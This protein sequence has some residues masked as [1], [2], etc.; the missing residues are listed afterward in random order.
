MRKP[1]QSSLLVDFSHHLGQTKDPFLTDLEQSLL[2]QR[3]HHLRTKSC[4]WGLYPQDHLRILTLT[5]YMQE[6]T[7]R[8]SNIT[9]GM[10]RES[11]SEQDMDPF[12][13]NRE[14][15]VPCLWRQFFLKYLTCVEKKEKTFIQVVSGVV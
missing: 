3:S 12:Y 7:E 10:A 15:E 4:R 2:V 6:A 14:G 5:F 9:H 1:F 11:P 8:V 13:R